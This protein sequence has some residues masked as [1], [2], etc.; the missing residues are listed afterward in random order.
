VEY[1]GKERRIE[2]QPMLPQ[3]QV[4]ISKINNEI[5]SIKEVNQHILLE[6]KE[7]KSLLN[8]NG[9]LGLFSKVQILWSASL[10]IVVTLAGVV[11]KMFVQ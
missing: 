3:C 4:A 2:E 11:V 6:I 7:I 1:T 8:G 5:T 9:K 10:F